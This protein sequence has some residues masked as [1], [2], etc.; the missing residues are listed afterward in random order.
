MLFTTISVSGICPHIDAEIL[1][2]GKYEVVNDK[3]LRFLS[4]KCPIEENA[5]INYYEQDEKYK[6]IQPCNNV[7]Q[8]PIASKFQKEISL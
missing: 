1:L 5:K 3:Y 2:V 6:Y 4:F 7:T 8:C